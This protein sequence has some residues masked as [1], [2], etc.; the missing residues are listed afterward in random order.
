MNNRAYSN[1][2]PLHPGVIIPIQPP[3]PQHTICTQCQHK[4]TASWTCGLDNGA[5]KTCSWFTPSMQPSHNPDNAAKA[6]SVLAAANN[7]KPARNQGYAI[8]AS[9][10]A[11][12]KA[13]ELADKEAAQQSFA[14]AIDDLHAAN[15][16]A[17]KNRL[18]EAARA[19]GLYNVPEHESAEAAMDRL[20]L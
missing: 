7:T 2:V 11:A 13:Q 6:H 16:S 1:V 9:A 5:V 20:G 3:K 8:A 10:I 19:Q 12:K 17:D 18:I 14:N 15:Q 4:S